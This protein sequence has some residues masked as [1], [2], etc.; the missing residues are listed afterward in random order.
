M[1]WA[2]GTYCDSQQCTYCKILSN[3]PLCSKLTTEVPLNS[4]YQI[5]PIV[6]FIRHTTN[7]IFYSII[8]G[9]CPKE[10]S[11]LYVVS[12][13]YICI[14]LKLSVPMIKLQNVYLYISHIVL[15]QCMFYA[16]LLH[17]THDL[18]HESSLLVQL[19][20]I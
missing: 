16:K 5:L 6:Y 12:I 15:P 3:T 8:M 4:K 2:Y 7:K 19:H 10:Y 20:I 11:L 1:L 13:Q 9:K 18:L 14:V 17:S